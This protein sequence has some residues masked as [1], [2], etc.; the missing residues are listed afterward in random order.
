MVGFAHA[1]LSLG[2]GL[3][4]AL[5]HLRS[6]NP[7]VITSMKVTGAS[8]GCCCCGRGEGAGQARVLPALGAAR[9]SMNAQA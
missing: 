9:G 7:Y 5:L 6:V 2:G 4:L 8:G 1:A 3:N